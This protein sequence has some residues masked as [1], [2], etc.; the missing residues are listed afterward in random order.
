MNATLLDDTALRDALL[1]ALPDG[2]C[3]LHADG[4]LDSASSKLSEIVGHPIEELRLRVPALPAATACDRDRLDEALRRAGEGDRA[5][6]RVTLERASGERFPARIEVVAVEEAGAP[7]LLC[8]VRDASVEERGREQL[9]E[10]ERVARLASWSWYPA[11]DRVE[12]SMALIELAGVAVPAPTLADLLAFVPAPHDERVRSAFAALVEDGG[13]SL[14]LEY[15]LDVPA[16]GLEWVETRGR[17]VRDADG[18]VACVRLTTQDVT[19]RRSAEEAGRRSED[20]LRQAQR[21]AEIGSFEVDSGTGRVCWSDEL[22][23]LYGMTPET[24]GGDLAGVRSL[25]PPAERERLRELGALTTED[26]RTRSVEHRYLRGAEV[27]WAESR[28]EPLVRDGTR[29]GVRGTQQDITERRKAERKILLQAHLLDAV[30]AAVVS[31]GLDGTIAHWSAGAERM[32]GWTRAEALGRP[33]GEVAH[34]LDPGAAERILAAVRE[35]GQWEGRYETAHK[36]GTRLPVYLRSSCFAMPGGE[37]TGI[38]G[39]AVDLTR[40]AE[41]ERQLRAARDYLRTVTDSMGECLAT[42]DLEGRLIYIN[43][44]GEELLGWRQDELTGRVMHDVIHFRRADGTSLSVED[45]SL[46]R[47]RQSGSSVHIPEDTFIRKDGRAVPVEIRTA[48]FETDDGLRGSVVLFSDITER[49]A[50][51]AELR[52]EMETL[53]WAGRIRDALADDRFVLYAQPIVD[54]T[55]GRTVQHELLI[56]MLDC[57]GRLIFPGEFLPLAEQS[58][59]IVHIDRWV[60]REAVALAARGQAVELNLSARSLADPRI[61]E[62]FRAEL[63]RTGADPSLIVVEL[64]ETALM[65]D[66]AAAEL[67]IER[68]GALGCKL[69]LDDFGTGYGGF[70]YLKRL[71]VD[72]LKIDMEFVRDLEVNVASRHVVTAVVSLARGFGQLTVAEGVENAATAELLRELGVDHGQGYHFA[73]PAPVCEVLMPRPAER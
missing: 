63:E 3:L 38:V 35:T 69:A 34:P 67:F 7:R 40:Q 37:A 66:E 50:K 13:E 32:Y 27:R 61:L 30:D 68:L 41:T 1:R 51:E 55:T 17:A 16:P 6:T 48:P 29:V 4:R 56:R 54:L 24:F 5:A 25:L 45:C 60:I 72:F 36:D 65:D 64:T 53:A 15:P 18:R 12:G 14:T 49:L 42:V 11:C 46:R 23:R 58:G 73:R 26:G 70:S 71:P 22:Y 57:D 62:A 52:A 44:A 20:R 39:V 59:L 33:I 21:T 47:A 10:V 31:T 2:V 43:R 19:A 8:L 9:R 28:M